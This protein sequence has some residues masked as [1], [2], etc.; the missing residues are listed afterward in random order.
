M[1]KNKIIY[2]MGLLT[3][4]L[5]LSSCNDYLDSMP[6]N[7]ATIDTE[8]KVLNLLTSAY[9]TS[10]YVLFNEMMSDN[11]DDYGE[12]NPNTDRFADQVFHW[13]DITEEDNDAPESF[14]ESTYSAIA[15]AN[16]ALEGIESMGGAT[17]QKLRQARAEALLCRAYNHFMLVNE[18]CRTYNDSTSS[19]DLG[20]PYM[21]RSNIDISEKFD[22]GTVADDYKL[23]D[24]DIQAAL[25]DVGDD[26]YTVPKYHFNRQAAYAF[27]ARFYLYYNKWDK[28][29]E[30][31]T[32]CLGSNPATLLRDYQVMAG[33]TQAYDAIAQHYISA[34][35][36]ANLLITTA[37]SNTGLV[38]GPYMFY[39]RYS[40][41]SYVGSYEDGYARNIWGS[42]SLERCPVRRY[43]GT[44]LNKYIYWRIPYM[45]EYTDPVAGI[46]YRHAVVPLFSTDECLLNRA[47]A[48]ALLKQYDKA[49]ADLNTW[50]HNFTRSTMT[51]TVDNINSFYGSV[52]YCYDDETHMGS[53]VKKHLNPVFKIDAEGSTQENLLQCVLGFK[54]METLQNGL[55]W[56]DVK[57]YRIRIPRRV[58][59]ADGTPARVDDWLETNDPRTAIQLPTKVISAGMT[60]NPR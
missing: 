50:M 11:C 54:R 39:S 2:S 56:F 29:V 41:G 40:H 31:A 32:Q 20:M 49:V 44:N 25:P 26:N 57:R 14:Y 7:R 59:G 37:T 52:G 48:Y 36:S 42:A 55:R 35:V 47:E 10:T 23:I 4:A 30:Y 18:F 45:F 12:N 43:S 60:P 13:K 53:T 27:A 24:A 34:D 58:I 6:D 16:A 19:T 28:A 21:T 1:K 17:T 22:R 15:S 46:G 38:F 5:T 3:A 9:P 33:M 8:A 51:L